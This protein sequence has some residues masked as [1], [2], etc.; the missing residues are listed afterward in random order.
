[1]SGSS[2][3]LVELVNAFETAEDINLVARSCV[4]FLR[5][6]PEKEK[7]H[8]RLCCAMVKRAEGGNAELN[9]LLHFSGDMQL[10]DV[11]YANIAHAK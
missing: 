2:A 3:K 5:N 1:M 4:E 10:L 8:R 7:A 11:V 6:S 9:S